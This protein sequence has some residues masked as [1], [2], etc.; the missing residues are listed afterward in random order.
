MFG[1]FLAVEKLYREVVYAGVNGARDITCVSVHYIT[2]TLHD[3]DVLLKVLSR[4]W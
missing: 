1:I 3:I 4:I 2:F